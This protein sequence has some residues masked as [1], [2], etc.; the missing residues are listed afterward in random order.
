MD[1]TA[2]LVVQLSSIQREGKLE[3]ERAFDAG[4]T[5]WYRWSRYVTLL[6]MFYVAFRF[7]AIFFHL[8]ILISCPPPTLTCPA[9][10]WYRAGVAVVHD[11]AGVA[12]GGN[13]VVGRSELGFE[14]PACHL[15][16]HLGKRRVRLGPHARL[17]A[18]RTSSPLCV[19]EEKR[20]IRTLLSE[21]KRD[22][23]ARRSRLMILDVI[24]TVC[25]SW[26]QTGAP[27]RVCEWV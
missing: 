5:M 2:V 11:V 26:M 21:R 3:A 22:M 19:R 16:P 17:L 10:V 24:D 18:E 13:G 15:S 12:K 7:C 6:S 4:G 25:R 20:L 9:A 8:F 1:R 14:L 27:Q 23:K